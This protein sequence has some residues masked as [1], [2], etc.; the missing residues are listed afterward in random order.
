MHNLVACPVKEVLLLNLGFIVSN[1]IGQATTPL[2]MQKQLML[3]LRYRRTSLKFYGIDRIN[4]MLQK[5]H[6]GSVKTQPF[7][8]LY[9]R[10]IRNRDAILN[11]DDIDLMPR[12]ARNNPW[13]KSIK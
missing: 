11:Y 10:G 9:T 12:E 6:F 3:K 8:R 7:V 1:T 13:F 2:R 5:C 4:Y